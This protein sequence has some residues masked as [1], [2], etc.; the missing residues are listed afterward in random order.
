MRS[1]TGGFSRRRAEM[2]ILALNAWGGAMFDDLAAW[3]PSVGAD[4][5]CLQEVTRTPGLG[6]WTDFRDAE[7]ELPQRADLFADVSRLLP[8]HQGSF[9]ASD[10]GPITDGDGSRHRQDFGL[11]IFVGE[12]IPV[13]GQHT[14]FVHGTFLDHGDEWQLADRPRLAQ[15]V[16]LLDRATTDTGDRAVSIVHTHGLRDPEGKHDTP[17]RVGQADRLVEVL[18]AV[19]ADGDVAVVVGDLNVLPDSVTFERLAAVGM[20]DLVGTADTRTSRYTKPIRHADYLL[21]SDPAVVAR[22]EIVSSP[23][24]SDHRPLLLDI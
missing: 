5:V 4:V 6:G 9:V 12:A 13:I 20:T 17:P 24:V 3:L 14:S 7:R 2:R 1:T 15:A 10:A 16:R 11:A 8:R 18:E 21:V 19:S 23:E 22:F